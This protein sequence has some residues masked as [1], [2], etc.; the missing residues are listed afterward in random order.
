MQIAERR[1]Q[2]GHGLSDLGLA[3]ICFGHRT[4]SGVSYQDTRSP[5]RDRTTRSSS[6]RLRASITRCY[7]PL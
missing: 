2:P 4:S 5:T 1:D 7:S 3:Y 6:S